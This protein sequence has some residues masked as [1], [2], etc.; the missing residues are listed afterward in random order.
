MRMKCF[1]DLSQEKDCN[2]VDPQFALNANPVISGSDIGLDIHAA[3]VHL[4]PSLRCVFELHTQGFK[5]EEIALMLFMTRD[6][7]HKRVQRARR[8][9]QIFLSD[10][11]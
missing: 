2:D 6:A 1:A 9:M 10:Y 7:V 5:A 3:L 8:E 4:S 11:L